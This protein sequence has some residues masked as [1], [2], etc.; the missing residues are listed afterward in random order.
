VVFFFDGFCI[1][2]SLFLVGFFF[3]FFG[4]LAMG[5]LITLSVGISPS[6]P[7][8]TTPTYQRPGDVAYDFEKAARFF[9]LLE[10]TPFPPPPPFSSTISVVSG[11]Q[12]IFYS[13]AAIL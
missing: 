5:S 13:V 4:S 11:Y 3:F 8:H 9:I 7:P 2:L 1:S 12:L 6:S 10:P